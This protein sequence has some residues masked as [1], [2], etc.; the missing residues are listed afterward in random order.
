VP[1]TV[2]RDI[3]PELFRIVYGLFPVLVHDEF[4]YTDC[5]QFNSQCP[6][7]KVIA[8]G[9][10]RSTHP[11]KDKTVRGGVP[12]YLPDRFQGRGHGRR[13]GDAPLVFP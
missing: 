8:Q 13:E 7:E 2:K 12:R 9:F 5:Q 10:P 6:A 3:P 11:F 4:V 1:Q